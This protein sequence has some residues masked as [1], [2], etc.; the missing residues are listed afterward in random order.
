VAATPLPVTQKTFIPN[1]AWYH[2]P[3]IMIRAASVTPGSPA[4][5]GTVPAASAVPGRKSLK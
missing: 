3:L 4:V 5:S 2:S 1:D